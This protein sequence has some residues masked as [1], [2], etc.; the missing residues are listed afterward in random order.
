ML[1]NLSH[2]IT[3]D[4]LNSSSFRPSKH[5]F[6]KNL[7]FQ[8]LTHQINP[9][10]IQMPDEFKPLS[11]A[12]AAPHS[13]KKPKLKIRRKGS[14]DKPKKDEQSVPVEA[15][16]AEKPTLINPL[17][18]SP[19]GLREEDNEQTNR[20]DD[21]SGED[22]EKLAKLLQVCF[23]KL[24]NNYLLFQTFVN[25]RKNQPPSNEDLKSSLI[26]TLMP[27]ISNTKLL[28]ATLP[29]WAVTQKVTTQRSRIETPRGKN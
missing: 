5:L 19:N 4:N 27:L 2:Q 1:I 11:V 7:I 13:N 3:P 21:L 24:I 28:S 14:V 15:K 17:N 6:F 20:S 16:L 9:A 26:P 22:Y 8:S 18:T 23:F 29:P 12:Q 25:R 10:A